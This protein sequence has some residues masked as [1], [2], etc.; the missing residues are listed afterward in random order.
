MRG[1]VSN[2][3]I[4]PRNE[5]THAMIFVPLQYTFVDQYLPKFLLLAPLIPRDYGEVLQALLL[6]VDE[7][8][9][10]VPLVIVIVLRVQAGEHSSAPRH[11]C[12]KSDLTWF[13][14]LS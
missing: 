2:P 12:K 3:T 9:P 4:C 1:V 8:L 10:P 5:A 7:S 14:S 6:A 11:E 13:F